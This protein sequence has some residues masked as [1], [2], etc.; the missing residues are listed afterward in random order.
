MKRRNKRTE[1]TGLERERRDK[2]LTCWKWCEVTDK[3][4]HHSGREREPCRVSRQP[5]GQQAACQHW[6]RPR[7]GGDATPHLPRLWGLLTNSSRPPPDTPTPGQHGASW[8]ASPAHQLRGQCWE[9]THWHPPILP[10][11]NTHI[12]VL[13][14]SFFNK[15]SWLFLRP[16]QHRLLQSNSYSFYLFRCLDCFKSRLHSCMDQDERR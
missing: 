4:A 14:S 1:R 10:P 3:Q 16:T 8:R 2:N 11:S 9:D 13:L 5:R 7:Q 6:S 15:R 12:Y